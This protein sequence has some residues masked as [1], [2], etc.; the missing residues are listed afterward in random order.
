VLRES[1]SCDP[2]AAIRTQR[3]TALPPPT[4]LSQWRVDLRCHKYVHSPNSA[5]CVCRWKCT[6]PRKVHC[7]ASAA[8][9]LDT[10][11]VT[12]DTRPVASR[13][14]APNSQVGAPPHMNSLSAVAAGETTRRTTG[15]VLSGKRRRRLLRCKRPSVHERAP[16]QANLPPRKLRGPGLLP[17]RWTWARGGIMSSEGDVLSRPPHLPSQIPL[18][19]RSRRR[20]SSLKWPPP[21]RR[22]GLRSLSPNLQ[23]P[24][25][26]LLGSQRRKQPRV[27]KPWQ[28][29]SQ[30]PN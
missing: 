7:N 19:S 10:R 11:S 30:P 4:S 13:V 29:N 18:L 20:P 21:G 27:S 3:K 14:A 1:C 24:P 12:A 23:Q 9:A 22:P 26:R 5:D 16:P 15:A 2:A 6:W 8:S 28:P 17:S 25:S